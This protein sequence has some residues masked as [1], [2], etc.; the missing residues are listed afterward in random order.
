MVA[1][2][3]DLDTV[4]EYMD[5]HMAATTFRGEDQTFLPT[6]YFDIVTA[7]SVVRHL[8]SK[9][10]NLYLGPQDQDDFIH[11]ILTEGRKM[12]ATCVYGDLPLTCVKTLF[13]Y[14]L[15]D[16]K[17]PFREDDCPAQK[18]KRKFKSSF[19][20]NQK[21]FNPAFF[22]LNSEHKWDGRMAKPVHLD[23]SKSSLLGQ[24]AFGDVYKIWIHPDQ[25]SFSSVKSLSIT[26]IHGINIDVRVLVR[27]ATSQ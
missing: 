18:N 9:D 25:R 20:E 6:P 11:K 27:K 5:D 13:E 10:G 8:V 16:A 12:F 21:R 19:L 24:G 7:E 1:P 3:Q 14:G 22:E 26:C 2:L 17:F 15:T 23:E 4:P